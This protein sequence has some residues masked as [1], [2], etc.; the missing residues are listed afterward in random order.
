MYVFGVQSPRLRGCASAQHGGIT[1]ERC[2]ATA[3]RNVQL[4]APT[5][6]VVILKK[7]LLCFGISFMS[8]QI[9]HFQSKSATGNLRGRSAM[10]AMVPINTR[11]SSIGLVQF[12]RSEVLT[13]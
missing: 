10:C 13:N 7:P 3:F 4:Q 8:S 2:Q 5:T 11:N 6:S 9:S 12:V 1:P